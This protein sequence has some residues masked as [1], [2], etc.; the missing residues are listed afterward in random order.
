MFRIKAKKTDAIR[1]VTTRT[2]LPVHNPTEP[3]HAFEVSTQKQ[4]ENAAEIPMDT[5]IHPPANVKDDASETRMEGET[6]T[7]PF[8]TQPALAPPQCLWEVSRRSSD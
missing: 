2:F 5:P 8:E 7:H 6:K 4:I 3:H 1:L